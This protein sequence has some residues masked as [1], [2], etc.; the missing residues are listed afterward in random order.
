M[1]WVADEIA[2]DEPKLRRYSNLAENSTIWN[3][4]VRLI[5]GPNGDAFRIHFVKIGIDIEKIVYNT[6]W[7]VSEKKQGVTVTTEQW[8]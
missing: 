3:C 2:R 5:L 7:K 8:A 4:S 6:C 1:N